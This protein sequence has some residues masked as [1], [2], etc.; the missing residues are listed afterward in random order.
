MI[1]WLV[2]PA[3]TLPNPLHDGVLSAAEAN[4]Y[5]GL[6]V[7]KRRA[8]WLL[9]RITAKQLA[10]SYLDNTTG[11]APSL[12]AIIVAAEPDGAP[13]AS[14]GGARLPVSLSI[15]HSHGTALCALVEASAGQ[16]LGCDIEWIEPRDPSFGAE[17]FT[18][19][20]QAQA[21]A[22]PE[23][24]VA[25]TALWSAKEAV[26]KAVREGLRIDTRQVEII[27][28]AVL[29]AEWSPLEIA[30]SAALASRFPGAWSGWVRRHEG[31]V[32]TMALRSSTA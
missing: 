10:Q 13:Y 26:L 21:A 28:P 23:P 18:A 8:D 9:G 32:L 29:G 11:R 25:L 4:V 7:E 1:H 24:D 31:F 6:T 5:A 12:D 15:S 16:S 20:E 3:A 30:V 27:L 17:F 19:R 22:S 14:L 2:Q